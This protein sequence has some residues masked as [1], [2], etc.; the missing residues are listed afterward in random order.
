MYYCVQSVQLHCSVRCAV[1]LFTRNA[2]M[3]YLPCTI[4]TMCTWECA[5]CTV[6]NVPCAMTNAMCNLQC[7]HCVMCTVHREECNVKYALCNVHIVYIVYIVHCALC[8]HS[9]ARCDRKQ[10]WNW[11]IFWFPNLKLLIICLRTDFR[12]FR[13]I[14]L[15]NFLIR[16]FS[17]FHSHLLENFWTFGQCSCW[18][19]NCDLVIVLCLD[20]EP[21]CVHCVI[22]L[23]SVSLCFER[24]LFVCFV[25]HCVEECCWLQ[26]PLGG[27]ASVWS[28]VWLDYTPLLLCFCVTV[29]FCVS[30]C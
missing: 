16:P 3:C 26:A 17:Q 12:I 25:F 2:L 11:S 27:W 13:G 1:F 22:C 9:A 23:F 21:W 15:S 7:A 4:C 8:K 6:H 20:G 5:I 18:Y 29:I 19:C 28:V 30:L 10:T 24:V 14:M